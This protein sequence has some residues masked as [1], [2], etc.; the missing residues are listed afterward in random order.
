[1]AL[2]TSGLLT[3]NDIHQEAGGSSGTACTLND[4]DIR[5]LNALVGTLY[6][7]PQGQP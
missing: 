2:A 1:M 4:T 5:G 3:L 7:L 6:L